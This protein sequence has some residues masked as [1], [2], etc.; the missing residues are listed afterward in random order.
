MGENGELGTVRRLA[1]QALMAMQARG[2]PPTPQNFAVWYEHQRGED[3]ALTRAIAS[4]DESDEGFTRKRSAELYQLYGCAA[5]H[6]RQVHLVS[7]RVSGLVDDVTSKLGIATSQTRDYGE[8]LSSL[9]LGLSAAIAPS[10]LVA[11]VRELENQTDL[12]HQRAGKLETELE[13]N[14]REI[15]NLKEDLANA[16]RAATTDPL[17]GLGNRKLFDD[18]FAM[19][20]ESARASGAPLS[21]LVT[22]IDHFKLFNDR[23]GHQ[24]GDAVLKLVADKLKRSVKGRDTVA[25]YGGEEFV[26][27]LPRTAETVAAELA[28]Q[29]RAEIAKSRLVVRNRGQDLGKV[30]ISIGV[31]QWQPGETPDECFRRADQALYRAKHEGRNRVVAAARTTQPVMAA[32]A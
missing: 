24:I 30:T 12:M 22:D 4:I 29:L 14:S 11:L 3:D 6:C 10:E 21:L 23:H 7:E 8:R 16:R 2:I 15:N 13:R 5:D 27:L 25:R 9:G 26:L 31:A 18:V 28:E 1:E 20:A 19:E 32:V 17:T